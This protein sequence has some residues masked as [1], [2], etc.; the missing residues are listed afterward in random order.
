[1]Q[2]HILGFGVQGSLGFYV[3]F[4]NLFAYSHNFYWYVFLE[5]GF[6]NGL[7]VHLFIRGPLFEELVNFLGAATTLRHHPK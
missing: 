4:C 5:L 6:V 2:T 1:M 3:Y 7:W